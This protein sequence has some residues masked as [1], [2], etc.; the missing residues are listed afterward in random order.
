[1]T[2][3]IVGFNML[4]IFVM[5]ILIIGDHSISH[6]IS[7][8]L[9]SEQPVS[10]VYH[11]GAPTSFQK[12]KYTPIVNNRD[13]SA[14]HYASLLDLDLIIP[15]NQIYQISDE[16]QST[17]S[18]LGIPTLLPSKQ[19]GYLELSKIKSKTILQ[20]LGIP[21]PNYQVF[22]YA[23]LVNLFFDI[24]RPFVFKFDQD[25]RR[26]LQTVIVNDENVMD[27]Y[28]ILKNS[29][30]QRFLAFMLGDFIDQKFIVESFIDIVREYSYHVL[31][32][33][34]NHVY[35]GSS[36]DYKKNNNG[37]VGVN[38][39]GMGSYGAV[40]VDN[41]VNEYVIKILN[42][43]KNNNSAYVGIMYLGVAVDQTG[44]PMI[45]EINTRTGDTEFH[46]ILPLI[47]NNVSELFYNAAVNKPLKP[48]EFSTDKSVAIRI[49]KSNTEN[50]NDHF[51]TRLKNIPPDIHAYQ[52]GILNDTF[53]GVLTTTAANVDQASDKIYSY[54]NSI[55]SS[56]FIFRSDIGY[57]K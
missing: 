49:V 7:L 44:V 41:V 52:S 37:D 30:K 50:K 2:L 54:L 9:C 29:G 3:F 28:E 18:R 40:N 56:N 35:L 4:N 23:K 43:L 31:C 20:E 13:T 55:D 11:Y 17:L 8:R 38:T 10:K 22:S 15:C 6:H 47:N 24:P 45:L 51:F 27:E 53:Q 14:L 19:N 16:Y 33:K 5:K 25:A 39:D 21:T 26:G 34:D 36:R 32:S 42:Y 57:L 46:N 1:M 48:I 12:G